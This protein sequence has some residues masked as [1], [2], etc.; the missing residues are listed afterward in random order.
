MMMTAD[1]I[2]RALETRGDSDERIHRAAADLLRRRGAKGIVVD[3]GCGIG[4][5]RD[6]ARDFTTSYIG[7]DVVRHPALPSDVTFR[8]A[9]LD[10]EPI[11]I[12][13]SSADIVVAIET[14]EHLENPHAFARELA[15]IARPGAWVVMTT[16]NQMSVLSLLSLVVR[17]RF[18]AFQDS[19]Y[20]VHRTA[21]LPSDL[22]R[23]AGD[24]GLSDAELAFTESGRLPLTALHYPHAIAHLFPRSLSDNVLM[25]ARKSP[26]SGSR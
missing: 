12:P 24:C 14:V 5:F 9:D 4:R 11:P 16:P 21:L 19:C 2:D 13:S 26:S 1:A 20:P 23:I 7:V 22:V 6:A 25:V 15:R 10:R 8:A 17:G 3:V 18:A